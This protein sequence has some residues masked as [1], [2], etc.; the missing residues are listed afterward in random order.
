MIEDTRRVLAAENA[1]ADAHY[2]RY[3]GDDYQPPEADDMGDIKIGD[4]Y[5]TQAPPQTLP[6]AIPIPDAS[7]SKAGGLSSLAKA[8]VLGSA[9]LGTGGTGFG[10]ATLLNAAKK[11]VPAVVDAVDDADTKYELRLAPREE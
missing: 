7:Q 11:V 8:A 4:T 1:V 3:M 5:I 9:L 2:R 6:Q 10:V